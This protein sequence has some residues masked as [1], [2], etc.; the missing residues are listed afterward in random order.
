M[1]DDY[2][3]SKDFRLED[4]EVPV[5]S[6]ANWGG[7]TLHLRGNIEGFNH[8]GSRFNHLRFITGRHALPFYDDE[9]VETQKSFLDAFLKGKDKDGWSDLGK[10]PPLTFPSSLEKSRETVTALKER[11]DVLQQTRA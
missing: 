9:E 5:L 3:A 10:I 2:Y 1:D 7:I 4:I 11:V 8:A 6:V